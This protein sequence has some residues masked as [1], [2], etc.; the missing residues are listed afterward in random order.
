MQAPFNI[1]SP[2]APVNLSYAPQGNLPTTVS[3]RRTA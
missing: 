3:T 2:Y 1:D